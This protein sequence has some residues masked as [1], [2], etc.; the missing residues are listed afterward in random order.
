MPL[1]KINTNSIASVSNTAITGTITAAQLAA[2]SVTST[3]ISANAVTTTALASNAITVSKLAQS[4]DITGLNW[5]GGHGVEIL[6]ASLGSGGVR[7]LILWPRA[8]DGATFAG[9]L[10]YTNYDGPQTVD[11][12][13]H[14][15]YPATL[16]NLNSAGGWAASATARISSGS[17]SVRRVTYNGSYYLAI[18]NS[19]ATNRDVR[20]SGLAHGLPTG[21]P[22]F[23]SSVSSDDG[24]LISI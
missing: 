16:G 1:S 8:N 9:Q 21:Y 7:W 20:M 10:C 4:Q 18:Y 3:Q 23:V 17:L 13:I 6:S 5:Y 14:N 11:I 12:H 19:G 15:G 24:T 2:N 22:F